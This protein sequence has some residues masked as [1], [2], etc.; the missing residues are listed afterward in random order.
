ME[1]IVETELGG[2]DDIDLGV[3]PELDGG[4]GID[5]GVEPELD[6]DDGIALGVDQKRDNKMGVMVVVATRTM[7][8]HRTTAPVQRL[9]L[10]NMIN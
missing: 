4:N 3:E 9:V 5:L 6:G 2:D 7:I 8:Y 1:G 10:P